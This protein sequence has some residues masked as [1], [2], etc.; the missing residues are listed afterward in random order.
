MDVSVTEVRQRLG[1]ILDLVSEGEEALVTRGGMPV[2]AI[3]P[4][5]EDPGA[6]RRPQGLAAHVG[7]L[8]R[9]EGFGEAVATVVSLRAVARDREPPGMG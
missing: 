3:V 4:A 2:A 6:G 1:E 9:V 7:A 8:A 5:P